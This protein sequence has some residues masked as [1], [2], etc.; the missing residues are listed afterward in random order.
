MFGLLL[1]KWT[2]MWKNVSMWNSR[3][4]LIYAVKI[5]LLFPVSVCPLWLASA[6]SRVPF[7]M[8]D[9]T[10]CAEICVSLQV[11]R[12]ENYRP[13][14]SKKIHLSQTITEETAIVVFI[15]RQYRLLLV[16]WETKHGV[17]A[18]FVCFVLLYVNEGL[19]IVALSLF[20]NQYANELSLNMAVYT[21]NVPP[22]V[23]H[24]LI[25]LLMEIYI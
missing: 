18:C 1:F 24:E 11:G 3:A 16:D 13:T 6:W 14:A 22:L 10:V 25:V 8:T 5:L 12:K 9:S 4:D 2:R 20:K 7:L 21:W 19:F 15:W 23:W 17:I